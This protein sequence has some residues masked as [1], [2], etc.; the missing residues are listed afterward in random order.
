MVALRYLVTV[1]VL[2]LFDTVPWVGL[3]CVS[4]VFSVHTHLFVTFYNIL[5]LYCG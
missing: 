1:S 5:T 4:V 2:C 3:Q